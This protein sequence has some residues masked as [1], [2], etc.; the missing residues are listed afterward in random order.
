[1]SLYDFRMTYDCWIC[2]TVLQTSK[3]LKNH[4]GAVHGRLKVVCGFCST[5]EST[6]KRVSDLKV[7]VRDKHSEKAGDLPPEM[8]SENNGFWC[9]LY[10][11]DYRRIITPSPR[12]SEQ[13]IYMRMTILDWA[14]DLKFKP[15]RSRGEFLAGW[16][17]PKS[18]T[19]TDAA[20]DNDDLDYFDVEE[21]PQL[22]YV[23]FVPGGIFADIEKG[24]EK[25]RLLISD[26]IFK[27]TPSMRSLSRRMASL[28]IPTQ[29]WSCSEWE[30]DGNK[31]HQTHL[32]RFI[33][34]DIKL[35]IKL[36]RRMVVVQSAPNKRVGSP[37]EATTKKPR[38][39]PSD[40]SP[41]HACEPPEEP[42]KLPLDEQTPVPD[43]VTCRQ[44]PISCERTELPASHRVTPC[45]TASAPSPD[46]KVSAKRSEYLMLDPLR[47]PKL[48]KR[49]DPLPLQPSQSYRATKLLKMGGM[50]HWQP[51]RRAWDAD[52][53][54][55][56]VEGNLTIFW[57]PRNW[58][59]LDPQQKLLQWQFA[60]M[61]ILR[62]RGEDYTSVH[63]SDVLDHFN[64]LALP[65]TA[66]HRAP[67]QSASYMIVRSRY[68]N[69]EVLRAIAN[70]ELRDSKW[71]SMLEA[72]AMMRDTTND[73]LLKECSKIKLR[74]TKD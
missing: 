33:G 42:S 37:M 72:G 57:P 9:S 11:D 69:Y 66:A 61:S 46:P 62:A 16:E 10:P 53:E 34:I 23:N 1:M 59:D 24:I 56:L 47:L 63:Q 28:P 20:D 14:K 45:M 44:V 60:A 25:F 5:V 43:P 29:P 6:F 48:K 65:G 27:D 15:S 32:A 26:D 74:L 40:T 22:V 41:R 55:S 36:Q 70:D 7:H 67:K 58:K 73:K 17:D 71:L 4:L 8:F 2:S 52:E 39:M 35:I 68:Y 31:D 50:P 51:A 19:L 30:D 49:Q 18:F 54:I 3:L 13:A 12:S 21:D 64:F 38:S